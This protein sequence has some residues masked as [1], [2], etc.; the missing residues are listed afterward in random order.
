MFSRTTP[1]EALPG[2]RTSRCGLTFGRNSIAI[3]VDIASKDG[4]LWTLYILFLYR[5][6]GTL[7]TFVRIRTCSN[8]AHAH[9]LLGLFTLLDHSRSRVLKDDFSGWAHAE[10]VICKDAMVS[11]SRVSGRLWV[12]GT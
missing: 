11:L 10:R 12:N 8:A 2:G 5:V 9:G 7:K 4:K 1:F 6:G 3:V